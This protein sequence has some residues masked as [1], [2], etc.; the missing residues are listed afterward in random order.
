M[1]E[2]IVDRHTL[3]DPAG[4]RKP[5]CS[6][7]ALVT[8]ALAGLSPAECASFNLDAPLYEQSG[9]AFTSTHSSTR[10]G[11][12]PFQIARAGAAISRCPCGHTQYFN[13]GRHLAAARDYRQL[14]QRALASWAHAVAAKSNGDEIL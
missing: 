11:D 5:D 2:W 10:A 9:R 3:R 8:L 4:Y 1:A 7:T 6:D 14:R 12:A 13:L